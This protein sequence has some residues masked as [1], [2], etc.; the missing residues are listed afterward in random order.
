MEEEHFSEGG[1]RNSLVVKKDVVPASLTEVSLGR[2]GQGLG[3][4]QVE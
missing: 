3:G 1:I 4:Y 2:K